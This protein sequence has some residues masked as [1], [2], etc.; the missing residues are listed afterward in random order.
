MGNKIKDKK[1]CLYIHTSP[2]NK[3]YIGITTDYK[4]RWNNNGVGYLHKNK[5]GK[6][7]QP[8]FAN[9]ILKYGWNNFQHNIIKDNLTKEE[10]F[11]Y[12]KLFI[13]LYLTTNSEYGYNLSI[14]GDAIFL[15]RHHTQ[16]TKDLISKK[17]IEQGVNKGEKNYWYGK[18]PL[19]KGKKT[20]IEFVEKA[21]KTRK[22]NFEKYG[23]TDAQKRVIEDNKKKVNQ[24]DMDGNL[25]KT[26]NGISDACEEYGISKSNVSAVCLRKRASSGARILSAGGYQWR[27]A[28]DCDDIAPYK[29]Q[30]QSVENIKKAVARIDDNG[31]I[32]QTF[33]SAV[34]CAKYFNINPC[35]VA[36]VC[37]GLYATTYGYKFKYIA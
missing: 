35:G 14:G 34:E 19:N 18:T 7:Q 10:A 29:R 13:Q 37:R 25:I 2:S 12:E 17:L 23:L 1:W 32:L 30:E 26:W 22:E 21:N 31:N 36:A 8:A 28:D 15:G 5:N 9:A 27:Y 4:H 3:A 24:Y 20:P 16:E 11:Y 33:D 6:Y